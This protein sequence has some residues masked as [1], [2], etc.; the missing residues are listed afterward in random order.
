MRHAR[1]P[2]RRLIAAHQEIGFHRHHGRQVIA[3]DHYP[4]PVGESGAGDG[5]L[6]ISGSDERRGGQAQER[7]QEWQGAATIQNNSSQGFPHKG[8]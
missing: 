3:D 6:G 5:G 1:K 2:I 7:D 4:H 8:W